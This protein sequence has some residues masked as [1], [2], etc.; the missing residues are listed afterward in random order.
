MVE[1]PYRRVDTSDDALAGV[2]PWQREASDDVWAASDE[3]DHPRLLVVEDNDELAR[4]IAESLPHNYRIRRA[5]NGQD[6][7]KQALEQVPDLILSDV[8]MPLMD[9]FT[10]CSQLKTD[11]RT[12]HIPVILLTAK[13]AV[14]NRLAGLSL[15]ADDYLTKP[16]QITELQLRVRNQL[17]NKQR[18]REWVQ[19]SLRNPDPASTP[20]SPE[21]TDPF[22]IRLYALF[23]ANLSDSGFGLDQ[24]MSEL[25]MSRTALFRKVKALTGLTAHELLRNYRLKQAAQLLRSHV[26]VSETAYQ[27]GFESAAYFSKCFRELYQLSPSEFAAQA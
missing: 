10:L 14:E 20:P 12:S 24:L 25:G 19:A 3:S 27:V 8:M 26:S 2:A 5:V 1:L 17:V 23:E 11:L 18:Q 21:T 6:G 7:L 22:L 16:F 9:G 15:G 4:F 13:S